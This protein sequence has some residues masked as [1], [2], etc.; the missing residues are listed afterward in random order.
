MKILFLGGPGTGK[1]TAG[2][3]LAETLN[4]PWISSGE[5]LRESKEQW[6]IEKLKT[7]ELF[8]DGMIAEL[9][10]P[11]VE[12]ARNVIIDGFPRTLQQAK[13]MVDRGVKIDL[14]LEMVIPLEE[15][16]ARLAARGRE[17]DIPEVV[18][19]RFAMYEQTKTE[20]LAFLAGHGVKVETID[21]VGT[22]DEVFQRV[23]EKVLAALKAEL[24]LQQNQSTQA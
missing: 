21:G 3:R 13:I 8:D 19:E 6:V 9:V 23:Q 15:A 14:I 7:A 11:R 2:K 12:S 18:E 22:M 1:S 10:L 4:W 20:I 16:Q 24:A 17:Q 5:I